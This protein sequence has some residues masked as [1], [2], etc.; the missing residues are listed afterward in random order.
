[1]LILGPRDP[2]S[3]MSDKVAPLSR[4]RL[5][6]LERPNGQDPG[7]GPILPMQRLWA[8]STS[9]PLAASRPSSE[10]ALRQK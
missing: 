8:G 9:L 5:Q 1:M 6:T 10:S 2:L 4:T 3:R 7:S